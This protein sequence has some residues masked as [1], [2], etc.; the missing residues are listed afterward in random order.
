MLRRRPDARRPQP[1]SRLQ[2]RS[3]RSEEIKLL[4]PVLKGTQWQPEACILYSHDNEWTQ[5]QPMQPNSY[6]QQRGHI[7]LFY[8]AL[9]DRNIPV[10][11]ARP[12]EDLSRYK[13]VIA[14]SLHLLAEEKYVA[15]SSTCKTGAHWS[16]RS[17]PQVGRR[18][19]SHPT[20]VIRTT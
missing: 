11:F 16:A 4:S 1:G 8:N 9:H 2:G 3:A 13:L 19:P 20:P 15:S 14:L 5:D 12:T 17:A 6:F 10:D 18:M 7:Q